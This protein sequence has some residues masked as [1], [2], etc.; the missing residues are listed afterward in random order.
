MPP[1]CHLNVIFFALQNARM[2]EK[3]VKTAFNHVF[4]CKRVF[5]V[6]KK[7]AFPFGTNKTFLHI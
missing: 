6:Q 3:H 4:T 2:P 7:N 5:F 1:N